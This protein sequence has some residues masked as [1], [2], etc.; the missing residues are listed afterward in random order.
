M[1]RLRRTGAAKWGAGAGLCWGV[2]F[3]CRPVDALVVGAVQALALLFPWPRS[4]L[5]WK[6]AVAGAVLA[7]LAVAALAAF[8]SATTGDWRKSGHEVKMGAAAHFGFRPLSRATVHTP[9]RGWQ[10]TRLRLRAL[11][12]NLLGWPLPNLL[13][14]LLP[15]LLGRARLREWWFLLPLP[16]LTLLFMTFWY[17]EICFP[18]RYLSAATPALFVLAAAG[19]SAL[20]SLHRG[21][22]AWGRLAVILLTG[23]GGLFLTVSWPYHAQRYGED[24]YDVENVLPR[25]LRDY[26]LR[27]AVVFMDAVGRGP[28]HGN[29]MNDYYATGFMRNDLD[30]QGDVV[31]ARNAGARNHELARAY[32]GRAYYLYR[33]DRHHRKAWLYRMTFDEN[34]HMSLDSVQPRTPDLLPRETADL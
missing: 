11:N 22:H 23:W 14:P 34:G 7:G 19:L 30:L 26:G 32:P 1:L 2:A 9:Q 15:F 4:I 21:G 5:W 28:V 25:V 24:Y 20:A 13:F 6:G 18:A 17:Y 8:Q 16:A 12:D 33:Y 3:L 29:E 27:N 31:F 10:H